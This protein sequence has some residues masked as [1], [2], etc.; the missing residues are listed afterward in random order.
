M[1]RR[2]HSIIAIIALVVSPLLLVR[3]GVRPGE[4]PAIDPVRAA[5]TGQPVDPIATAVTTSPLARVF[6]IGASASAGFQLRADDGRALSIANVLDATI[7]AE[8]DPVRSA[9]TTLFFVQPR[10]AGD[11]NLRLALAAEPTLV[12]AL[13][14]LFWYGYGVKASEDDRLRDLELGL[15]QLDRLAC[16]VLIARIPDMRAAIGK[17]LTRAQ[18]PQAA[19][20]VAL[21]RR[22]DEWASARSH[23][24]IVPLVEFIDRAKSGEPVGVGT[25]SFPAGAV[26]RLVQSDDLHPTLEGLAAMAVLALET[27]A[28]RRAGVAPEAFERDAAAIAAQVQ[29][30]AARSE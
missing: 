14:F 26:G 23:V 19:T 28:S 10:V 13:D 25:T 22:I 9:A 12:V 11:T 1:K 17:M 18:V 24:V 27:W 6:V 15:A 3:C 21:N 7:R 30:G 29:G 20:I 2:L 4:A 16:D 8:H 5:N